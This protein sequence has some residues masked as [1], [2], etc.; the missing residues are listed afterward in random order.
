MAY[1]AGSLV[2]ARGRAFRSRGFLTSLLAPLEISATAVQ[3]VKEI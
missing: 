2:K 3:K 1:T